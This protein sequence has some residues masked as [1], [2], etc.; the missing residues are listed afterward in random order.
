M[1][2]RP[3]LL[4]VL[5]GGASALGPTAAAAHVKWFEEPAQ[6]P[7][8]TDLILSER[9]ALLVVSA[10][11]ALG[12]L[13]GLQRLLGSPHWPEVAFLRMMAIGGPTLLAVQAAIGLIHAGAHLAL[14]AP[15]LPLPQDALGLGLAAVQIVI[16]FSFIT[17]IG[18]WLSALALIALW[19]A[20]FLLFPPFDV[21]EQ[22]FWTG[23]GVV[24]L[25]IGR[26]AIDGREA[27]PWF[28]QHNPRWSLRAIAALRII[29]GLSIVAPALGE[30]LWNPELGAAFL[31]H[32]PEFNFLRTYLGLT[33]FTDERFVLV[34]GLAEAIIGILL[35]SGLLTRVVILGMWLPF[36]A[37]LPFLPPQELLGHLPIFGIMY[38]LLVHSAGIAPG[39]AQEI[40]R[41]V[42]LARSTP[43][44]RRTL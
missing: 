9:T 31:A 2:A 41:V 34:A 44:R 24:L 29:T 4:G 42:P 21:L 39:T 19:A 6:Y 16:A 11:V 22:L 40:S 20:G 17:G 26:F 10:L 3:G 35:A 5:A 28:R 27:R 36:N 8:R 43:N 7:L 30:K 18:D 37:G 33:W 12:V 38:L 14:F 1:S 13:Y 32:H 25:V 15:N 23:I